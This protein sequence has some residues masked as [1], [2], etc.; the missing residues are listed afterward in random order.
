MWKWYPMLQCLILL[1]KAGSLSPG[2]RS[3]LPPSCTDLEGTS[4]SL[5]SPGTSFSFANSCMAP[6]PQARQASSRNLRPSGGS[7]GLLHHTTEALYSLPKCGEAVVVV[8]VV[9]VVVAVVVLAPT[10]VL[11]VVLAPLLQLLS[12]PLL[13]SLLALPLGRGR[14]CGA[15]PLAPHS[16]PL[17]WEALSP[18]TGASALEPVQALEQA[19]EPLPLLLKQPAG[20]TSSIGW[21]LAPCASTWPDRHA[22]C[23]VKKQALGMP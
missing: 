6:S 22:P 12:L 16:S 18:L 13:L 19:L 9:V 15:G 17:S 10:L 20:E 2:H 14:P 1:V 8:V 3:L 11:A 4:S 23:L 21:L 7:Q 5:I